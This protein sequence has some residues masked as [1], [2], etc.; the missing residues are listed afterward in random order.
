MALSSLPGIGPATVLRCHRESGA[1]TSWQAIVSGHPDRVEALAAQLARRNAVPAETLV[2]AARRISPADELF[3]HRSLGRR[4]MVLGRPGYPQRLVEDPAP[5]AVLFA[6]GSTEAL[7]GPTVAIVGTRNATRAGRELA[8]SLG[9]ELARAGVAVVS[10]LALGIDGAAHEGAL[11]ASSRRPSSG[12]TPGDGSAPV[13]EEAVP[14]RPIGVIAA[15]LD[16][17]YPRRHADLHVNVAGSGVLVSETPLGMRPT[18]WR[19]PARNRIIAGLAD[20]VV[21]V[22]SRVTGGSILTANEAVD[23]GTTVFAVPGHPTSPS[24]AGTNDLIYDGATVFRSARDVLEVIGVATSPAPTREERSLA[25]LSPDQ[26]SVLAAVGEVPAALPE[27]L[28]RT[29]L[30][31]EEVSQVLIVLEAQGR[32]VRSGGWYE[33]S[34]TGSTPGTDR[35]TRR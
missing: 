18:A 17:V 5:P 7:E 19:F 30:L 25:A 26:R 35:S 23:R 3:R 21:V 20:A 24:A 28:A 27:I 16:I 33:R 13:G 31:L 4:I 10:G 29:G 34:G 8:R 2:A 1:A 32:L 22:E 11:R 6:S 15:G 14:G 9:E 12:S